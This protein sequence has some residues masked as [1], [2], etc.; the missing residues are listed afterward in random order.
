[1]LACSDHTAQIVFVLIGLAGSMMASNRVHYDLV[2]S[3]GN[4]RFADFLKIGLPLAL[5]IGAITVLVTP[6]VFP[7]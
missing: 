7:F 5:V 3:S 6:W 2:V 1:M 4:Y